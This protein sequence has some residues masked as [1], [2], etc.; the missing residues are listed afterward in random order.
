MVNGIFR[1]FEH[2]RKIVHKGIKPI[3]KFL[4]SLISHSFEIIKL[5]RK[6]NI[7]FVFHKSFYDNISKSFPSGNHF[8]KDISIP[9]L[10]IPCER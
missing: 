2:F 3:V 9:L 8:G 7:I 5:A 10:D 1:R 6:R 4:N